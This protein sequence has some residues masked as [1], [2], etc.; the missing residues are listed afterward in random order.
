[1][2]EVGIVKNTSK[3]VIITWFAIN[4]CQI[5]KILS[6]YKIYHELLSRNGKLNSETNLSFKTRL[7]KT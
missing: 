4:K 5:R 3:N 7:K 6:N 2:L 1:M